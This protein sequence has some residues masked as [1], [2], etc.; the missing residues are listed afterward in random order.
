[1]N[2]ATLDFSLGIHGSDG[3]REAGQSVDGEDQHVIYAPVFELIEHAE[4]VLGGFAVAKPNP[5]ALLAPL[6]V[7]ADHHI[8]SNVFDAAIHPELEKQ[9]VHEH[10]GVNRLQRPVLPFLGLVDDSVHCP[11][12]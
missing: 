12:C 9:R 10:N 4:P 11:I 1:M 8:G 7:D 3:F 6:Q 2:Q 5:E